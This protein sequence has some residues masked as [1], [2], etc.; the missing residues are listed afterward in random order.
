MHLPCIV[1]VDRQRSPAIN[2]HNINYKCNMVDYSRTTCQD[3][4]GVRLVSR[5]DVYDN[6]TRNKVVIANRYESGDFIIN[7]NTCMVVVFEEII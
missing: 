1:E 7:L 6:V 2:I 3:F 4:G 5:E